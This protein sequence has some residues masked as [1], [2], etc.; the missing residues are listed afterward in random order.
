MENAILTGIGL[1]APAGLN[2]YIP[3]L[4]LALADRVTT[5]ITLTAPYDALSS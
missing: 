4:V 3:L 1:A 2:A 5:R